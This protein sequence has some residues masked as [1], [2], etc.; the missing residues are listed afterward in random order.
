MTEPGADRDAILHLFVAYNLVVVVAA[1]A[2]LVVGRLLTVTPDQLG[3]V[4]LGVVHNDA[5]PFL[6]AQ[7]FPCLTCGMTRSIAAACD[8]QLMESWRLNPGG[9]TLVSLVGLLGAVAFFD[10]IR[11]LRRLPSRLRQQSSLI[12]GACLGW[13][14]LLLASWGLCVAGLRA[15]PPHM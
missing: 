1:V 13:L 6:L 10:T 14:V 8:F 5:C 12:L 4:F 7:G 11:L 15:A 2:C 3:V 9:P